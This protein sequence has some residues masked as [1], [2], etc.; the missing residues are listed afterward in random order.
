MR[1]LLGVYILYWFLN[2][3]PLLRNLKT[4]KA[5]KQKGYVYGFT[6]VGYVLP[7]IKI[8]LS[9]YEDSRMS[10][11]RTAA[12]MGTI[13]YLNLEVKDRRYVESYLHTHYKL[14]RLKTYGLIDNEWFI[15][16]PHMLLDM[17][18]IRMVY[19]FSLRTILICLGITIAYTLQLGVTWLLIHGILTVI[20]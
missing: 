6:D 9:K 4:R 3:I 13:L 2:L 18:V 16:L 8:G 1:L 10:S 20:T 11:H 7:F 12:A 5:Y 17:L 14:F 19:Q 15:M